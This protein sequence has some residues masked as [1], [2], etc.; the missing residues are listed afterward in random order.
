[1]VDPDLASARRA[2]LDLG[3]D[4]RARRALERGAESARRL[5][6]PARERGELL[7]R[8]R[9]LRP[10]D[11]LALVRE[12]LVQDRHAALASTSR[13]SRS[14][15][16]P[17]SMLSRAR[18]RPC[19]RSGAASATQRAAAAF[20]Q[21]ISRGAPGSPASTPPTLAALPPA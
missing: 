11:L 13:A 12:D 19:A 7:G 21:A 8:E 14:A 17:E 1:E 15:A 18:A 5:R 16:A 9:A 10:R 6:P 4:A 2:A 3:D 20:R